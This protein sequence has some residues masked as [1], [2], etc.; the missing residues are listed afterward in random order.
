[1]NHPSYSLPVNEKGSFT[2]R[3]LRCL[4]A[5]KDQDWKA[6]KKIPLL[7]RVTLDMHGLTWDGKLTEL[8]DKVL[9]NNRKM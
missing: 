8:G 2:V 6:Y 3:Q 4:Q 5:V 1:M 9:L 7:I